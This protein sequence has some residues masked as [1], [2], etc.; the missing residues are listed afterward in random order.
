MTGVANLLDEAI[1]LASQIQDDLSTEEG[2]KCK[3]VDFCKE[4]EENNDIETLKNK[5]RDFATLFD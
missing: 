2:K 4:L 3:L 1:Q 5:V